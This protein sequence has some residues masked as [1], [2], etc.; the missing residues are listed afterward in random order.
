M[1][2][3]GKYLYE[4]EPG[5]WV[6]RQRVNQLRN[7]K[8]HLARLNVNLAIK[9]GTLKRQPCEKCGKRNAQ[10]HH[11][12]YDDPYAIM[13]LCEKH[14]THPKP[15]ILKG[16]PIDVNLGRRGKPK[17][18][19]ISPSKRILLARNALDNHQKRTL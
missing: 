18:K 1:N 14:H 8:A 2:V 11:L 4:V 12:S 10:V 15:H 7:R 9:R 13:W 6:S 5:R 16:K 17:G 19:W 3:N